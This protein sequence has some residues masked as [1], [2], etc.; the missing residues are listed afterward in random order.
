MFPLKNGT[1]TTAINWGISTDLPVTR[2]S[3][4]DGRS[5]VGVYLPSAHTFYLRNGTAFS[6]TRTA[7]I[8]GTSMDLLVTGKW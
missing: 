6:W 1:T 4:G 8:W 3:N 5:D 7:I 2:D